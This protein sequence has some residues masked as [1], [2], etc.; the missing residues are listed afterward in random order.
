MSDEIARV[1]EI[2][3]IDRSKLI[4]ESISNFVEG[5]ILK[6][7]KR[8]GKLWLENDMLNKKYGMS[9]EDLCKGLDKMENKER[10]EEKEIGRVSILEAVSDTRKWEHILE[11]L[12][13]EEARYMKLVESKKK[14]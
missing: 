8:I 12:E 5:E 3:G 13:K 9:L 6:C 10:Y 11:D 2:F 4:A 14:G 1:A 7:E